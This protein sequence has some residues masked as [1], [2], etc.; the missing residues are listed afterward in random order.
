MKQIRKALVG[1]AAAAAAALGT[2]MLD[3]DLTTA[4][5]LV[6]AGTGLIALAAVYTVP[7]RGNRVTGRRARP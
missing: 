4:E 6:S 2:A 1:G 5:A 3:G 7:N